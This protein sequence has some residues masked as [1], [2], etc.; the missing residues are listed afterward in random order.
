MTI[1]AASSTIGVLLVLAG[2]YGM[3]AVIRAQTKALIFAGAS[4]STIASAAFATIAVG[5]AFGLYPALTASRLS[6]IDAIRH[7]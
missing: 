1:C 3:T 5:L 2:A 4:V 7:E 6:P